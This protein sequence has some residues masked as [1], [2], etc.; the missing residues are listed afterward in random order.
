M[1]EPRRP[2]DPA[3]PDHRAWLDQLVQR[4]SAHG[5]SSGAEVSLEA[6]VAAGLEEARLT[7]WQHICPE[8]HHDADWDTVDQPAEVRGLMRRFVADLRWREPRNFLFTGNPGTGKTFAALAVARACHFANVRV[9]VVRAG[10]VIRALQPDG[11]GLP[12]QVRT[13]DLLVLDE[14]G[15]RRLTDF[16]VDEIEELVSERYDRRRSTIVTTNLD[17]DSLSAAFGPRTADRLRSN[18]FAVCLD[19]PSRRRPV[20]TDGGHHTGTGPS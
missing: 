4:C 15:A 16:V 19:G 11:G 2:L 9:R 14:L 12:P 18:G 6:E 20:G 13:V 5:A 7:A 3:D 10:A 8:E 1:T 17:F